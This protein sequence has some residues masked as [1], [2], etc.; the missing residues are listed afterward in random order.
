MGCVGALGKGKGE[1]NRCGERKTISTIHAFFLSL[2]QL[3]DR[4]IIGV[5]LKSLAL[6]LVIFAALGVGLW[7]GTH[8]IAHWSRAGAEGEG[9]ASLAT[10]VLLLLAHWLLFRAVAIAVIG[11]F[12]DEVVHVVEAEHYPEALARARPVPFARALGMGLGSAARAI[13]V[14][15]LL[16]PLYLML[17][18][19]G[20]GT[21]IAFFL[22]NA[23]LLGR[24][25]GDMV[26]ARHMPFE[27]LAEWRGRTRASRFLLGSAGTALLL[28]PIVNLFAPVLGAAMATHQ[29]HRG[30]K[31]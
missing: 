3:G 13:L 19:T 6:T 21:P 31:A 14:N 26:A 8:G 1:C 10:L 16:A 15:L 9:L 22:V 25:L 28:V 20:I 2:G 30:R 7:Y 12:G 29:F 17:I 11:I 4:R 27:A 23:W 18:V 24:D 5:F